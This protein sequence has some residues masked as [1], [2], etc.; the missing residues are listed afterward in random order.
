MGS[1]RRGPHRTSGYAG[2]TPAG[3][4][5]RIPP[6][7]APTPPG[8]HVKQILD[9][10][11]AGDTPRRTSPRLE[12][13]ESYRA[14]TVH[15]D[16]VD[17]FEGMATKEKDP[18]KS[19]HVDDV[20]LPE[21]GPGEALVAVMA[22]AINYNTVWTSIF[23]PVST[24]GFLERYGRLSPAGQA[25]RPAVPRRRLRPGRRRAADRPRRAHVEARRRGRR[26]LPVGRAGGPGRPQRHDARPRAADLGLR[27]QLRR[28]RRHRAGQ[29]QPAD[30]EARP[31]DLG[32]GRLPGPGQL[33]GVP[34]AGQ[35]ATAAT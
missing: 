5:P 34:P 19:L 24:F 18:R 32:G 3:R 25:A 6:A 35:Q 26:A 28:A 15:K 33:H 8:A 2:S 16:E 30:A 1:V 12:L 21:L 20:A 23:E 14:V 7:S 11:L 13:P 9:A 22:S 4:P 10:I 29:G 27:D 17:M 31:P